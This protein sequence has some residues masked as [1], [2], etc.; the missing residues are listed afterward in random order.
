M[1]LIDDAI[2]QLAAHRQL[3]HEIDVS[4]RLVDGA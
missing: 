4:R 2:E 3:D 1:L